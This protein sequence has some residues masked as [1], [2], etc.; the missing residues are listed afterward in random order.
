MKGLANLA[1][2]SLLAVCSLGCA[3]TT[4]TLRQDRAEDER[5][6]RKIILDRVESFNR[7]EPPRSSA[8]TSDADF[9]NVHGLW[10]KG[11]VEIESRQKER[12]DTVL[13]EAKITLQNVIVRFIRP[14]VAVVH[15]LHEMSGMSGETGETL[16][17]FQELS[18]RVMVKERGQWLIAA[19]HN[20]IVR[21]AKAAPRAE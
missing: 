5:A 21:E 16:P 11:A 6:I 14:D 18:I 10:R 19:F 4:G 17:P 1:L 2:A 3:A 20:T 8:F 15:E 7:H 9:V 12:M 13:R